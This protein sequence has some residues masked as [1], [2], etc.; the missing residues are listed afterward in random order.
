MA[1]S[2]AFNV[3]IAVAPFLILLLIG[4]TLLPN[5]FKITLVQASQN[6]LG[7]DAGLFMG[8]IV[9]GAQQN[10]YYNG[11]SG[12][13]SLLV[14][15]FSASSIFSQLQYGM[16]KINNTTAPVRAWSF[17]LFLKERLVF[18]VFLFGMVLLVLSSVALSTL[19]HGFMQGQQALMYIAF[20]FVMTVALQT[21]VF[22]SVFHFV[23]T[24]RL[25]WHRSFVSGF[26]AA[27]FFALG[28]ELV[29]LYLGRTA[30]AS[31]NGAAGS[32]ILF[33]LWLYYCCLSFYVSQEFT[34]R[35]VFN[36]EGY[37]APGR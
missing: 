17:K 11:W 30:V 19:A 16:D 33:L 10:Q 32:A 13:L 34:N 23:P 18:L 12:F 6:F 36:D 35:V 8:M 24:Q 3:A 2:L 4:A 5:S 22:A 20:S 29:S 9:R 31:L 1:S 7:P 21:L 27:L 14:I 25:S 37:S 26:I 15:I 28:K